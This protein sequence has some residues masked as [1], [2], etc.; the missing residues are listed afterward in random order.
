M[1]LIDSDLSRSHVNEV[2]AFYQLFAEGAGDQAKAPTNRPLIELMVT[3][4]GETNV[5]AKGGHVIPS[6]TAPPVRAAASHSPMFA[7]GTFWTCF[8]WIAKAQADARARGEPKGWKKGHSSPDAKRAALVKLFK[9]VLPASV[10]E[11]MYARIKL[12]SW[13]RPGRRIEPPP[14]TPLQPKPSADP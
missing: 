7:E 13:D 9:R 11:R 10:Y 12:Y 14:A 2:I 1:K 6:D 4:D 5:Y 3:E 8:A